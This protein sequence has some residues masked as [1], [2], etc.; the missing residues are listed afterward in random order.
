MKIATWNVNSI[1]Q[2][3]DHVRRWLDEAKPDVLLLQELKCV[4]EN[5]P[6]LEIEDAGYNVEVHGQ[7]AFNGVAILSRHEIEDVT[8]GLPHEPA[9]PKGDTQARYI[10]A[11]VKGVRVASIYLPNGNPAPG[12]KFDYKLEW[13]DRLADHA[14]TLRATEQPV[15]LAGD[16]NICPRDED[17]YDAPNW[18]DDA[19]LRPDSRARFRTLLNMGYYDA[20]RAVVPSGPYYTYW[21]YKA[22]AW[23]KDMGLR[24]DH[25]LLS[26]PAVDL[27]ASCEI[28]KNP[29][30]WE[31]AS[32]HTPIWCSL[33]IA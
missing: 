21:D 22:G 9:A 25:L 18:Q 13:M 30:G 3:L 20:F 26:P 17:C 23:Q 24:I 8:R 14:R 4:D 29:R 5:F 12:E 16:Y 10:E 19:L 27:L 31:K 2:R 6:R 1:K 15:V 11:T 33:K 7:K 32:D 28:D